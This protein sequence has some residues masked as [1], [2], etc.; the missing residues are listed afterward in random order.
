LIDREGTCVTV[1]ARF[2]VDATGRSAG[3]STQLGAERRPLD[4]QVAVMRTAALEE[5]SPVETQTLVEA[6][7]EG[8]WY[9]AKVP[10]GGIVVGLMSDADLVRDRGLWRERTWEG[11]LSRTS[12]TSLRV[13][14]GAFTGPPRAV[15]AGSAC[16]SRLSGKRWIAV[17][18]A[19]ASH[20]PLSS[21]GIVRALDSGIF[22]ARAV[23]AALIQDRRDEIIHYEARMRDGFERFAATWA[24]YYGMEQRF[25]ESA[26]WRRRQRSIRIDP[27]A[28]LVRG[29]KGAPPRLPLDLARIDPDLI[30]SLCEKPCP[31]HEIVARYRSRAERPAE[32]AAIIVALQ[33]LS[34]EGALA[35]ASAG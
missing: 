34:G 8:W 11:L 27:R 7:P 19:A 30:L 13:K 32:D 26:Y 31:A 25:P 35:G 15:A 2:L 20:D 4:R 12:H 28:V 10:G 17:G 14:G 3:L 9:S 29:A 1:R 22:G 18:D 5:G 33:W 21:S 16:L 6:C 24:R 23:A